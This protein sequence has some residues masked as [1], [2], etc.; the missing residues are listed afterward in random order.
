M[1]LLVS[2]A[3]AVLHKD[4]QGYKMTK[5]KRKCSHNGHVPQN[6]HQELN[7]VLVWGRT[8]KPSARG[9]TVFKSIR[10]ERF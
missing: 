7:T 8:L 4:R 6:V 3:S 1:L 2:P 5:N 9:L 10:Q